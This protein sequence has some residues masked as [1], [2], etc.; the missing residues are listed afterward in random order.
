[1]SNLAGR[2]VRRC[3]QFGHGDPAAGIGG[4]FPGADQP[5]QQPPSRLFAVSV[6]LFIHGV[7]GVSHGLIDPPGEPVRCHRHSSALSVLPGLLERVGQQRKSAGLVAG[8]G[9]APKVGQEHLDQAGIDD[10]PGRDGGLLYRCAQPHLVHRSDKHTILQVR[11]QLWV[12]AASEEIG[13]YPD[14]H[15]RRTGSQRTRHLSER[16]RPRT[17]SR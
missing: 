14:H 17:L 6:E 13:A 1:M 15:E 2:G 12:C 11:H 4:A 16:R 7:G 9:V 8:V 3:C 5:E 10:E